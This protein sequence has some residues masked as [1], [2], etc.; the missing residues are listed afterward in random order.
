MN[1]NDKVIVYAEMNHGGSISENE[2]RKIIQMFQNRGFT[3]AWYE[4]VPANKFIRA[5]GKMKSFWDSLE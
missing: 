2:L 5:I 1:D 4:R 3:S